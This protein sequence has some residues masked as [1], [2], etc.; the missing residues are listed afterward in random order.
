LNSNNENHQAT[1]QSSSDVQ[2]NNMKSFPDLKNMD[3]NSMLKFVQDNPQILNMMGPQMSKM[4]GGGMG[5]A[6]GMNNEVMMNSMQNILWIMSLPQRIRAFFTSTR[7]M[8]FSLFI[9]IL[10]FSYLYK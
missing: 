2:P 1:D 6:N 4:F 10:I 3:M 9:I 7:G 8:M 5:G